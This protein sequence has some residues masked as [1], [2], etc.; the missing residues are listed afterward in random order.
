[1]VIEP[2]A[3]C[4]N[5]QDQR[6]NHECAMLL[7]CTVSSQ[8]VEV[9][10]QFGMMTSDILNHYKLFIIMDKKPRVAERRPYRPPRDHS[11]H[12]TQ[13][14]TALSPASPPQD[15]SKPQGAVKRQTAQCTGSQAGR[16]LSIIILKLHNRQT[17]I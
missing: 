9:I 16:H 11:Q 4:T 12:R 10:L 14:V 13:P 1:M 7:L 3:L 5:K 6:H 15:R 8:A 17:S 2:Y